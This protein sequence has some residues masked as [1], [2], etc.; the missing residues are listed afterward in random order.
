MYN[1]ATKRVILP[2]DLK[3]HI[4]DGANVENEPIFLTLLKAQYRKQA[5]G[6]MQ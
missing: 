5:L 2:R 1:P 4:F 6:R 3:C